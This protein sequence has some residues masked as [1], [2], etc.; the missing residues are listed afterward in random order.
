MATLADFNSQPEPALTLNDFAGAPS[1]APQSSV[2]SDTAINMAAHAAL[3]SP[4]DQVGPTY[5][6]V[7]TELQTNGTSPTL[8]NVVS[9]VDALDEAAKYQTVQ[10]ALADPT[11]SVDDKTKLL[12]AYTND[13]VVTSSTLSQKVAT[14]AA[15]APSNPAQDN[16][17]TEFT[18]INVVNTMDQVDAYNGYVSQQANAIRNVN[19][20][21]GLSNTLD[22][23]EG[24]VPFLPEASQA[25]F[26][27][28]LGDKSPSSVLKAMTLL[29]EN[30]QETADA[31]AAMPVAQRQQFAETVVNA[32]KNSGGSI[33]QRPNDLN[34]LQEVTESLQS[35]AYTGTDRFLDDLNS[36]L[37]LTIVGGPVY[38]VA[39]NFVKGISTIAGGSRSAAD[40]ARANAAVDRLSKVTDEAVTSAQAAEAA[41]TEA[42]AAQAT[43]TP[44][45]PI[46]AAGE[47]PTSQLD[48]SNQTTNP[49]SLSGDT[50]EATRKIITDN[51]HK[52]MSDMGAPPSVIADVKKQIGDMITPTTLADPKLPLQIT[53]RMRKVFQSAS[54]DPI[55][56]QTLKD[57]RDYVTARS[58]IERRT[59]RTDVDF[60]SPSQTIKDVNPGKARALFEAS[61]ADETGNVAKALYGTTPDEAAGNDILPEIAEQGGTVRGKVSQNDV[62]PEPDQDL[63]FWNNKSRGMNYFSTAEKDA[64]RNTVASDFNNVVGLTPRREMQQIDNTDTGVRISQVYGP[65]DGGFAKASDAANQVKFALRKYGV[66]DKDVEVLGRNAEG[67]FAP[68]DPKTA[69][70]GEYVARVNYNY[71]FDPTDTVNWTMTSSNKFARMFDSIPN[72]VL[73]GRS[74]GI[75]DHVFP[76]VNINDDLITRGANTVAEKSGSIYRGFEKLGRDWASKLNK[77]PDDQK[78][79]VQ[80]YILKAN[81][82]GIKFNAQAMKA[83]GFSD[84]AVDTVRAWK[85]TWDTMWHYENIDLNQSLRARGWQRYVDDSGKSDLVV[86]PV[87]KGNVG[88]A[89]DLMDGAGAVTHLTDDELNKLYEAGG[90]V[91]EIRRPLM[92][93]GKVIDKIIVKNNSEGSYLRRILDHDPTLNYRDG[94]YAVRYNQPYFITKIMKGSN[95]REFEQAVATAGSRQEA[96]ALLDR[97]HSTDAQGSY[98]LRGDVKR[99][100]PRYDDYNWDQIVSSGRSPQRIRGKRLVDGNAVVTDPN[101]INI[102]T[103]QDSLVASM[104]SIS[105]RIVSRQYIEAAKRRWLN[106][107]ADTLK[108]GDTGVFPS[109]VRDVGRHTKLLNLSHVG[110]AKVT[111]RY[112]NMM[113]NGYN[114]LI[115]DGSKALFNYMSD[116]SGRSKSWAW[117][118]KPLRTGGKYGPIGAV[119]KKAFRLFLAANP[120]RQA[121]VQAMQ[122]VPT[123]LATNPMGI[124]RTAARIPL[125]EGFRRGLTAE[126]MNIWFDKASQLITGL[127][128]DQA[129]QMYE[130]WKMSGYDA[131]VTNNSLIRDDLTRLRDQNFVQKLNSVSKIPLDVGQKIGFEFGEGLLMNSMWLSEYDKLLN[132]GVKI[133]PEVL[134]NMN[135]RVRNLTG[136]MNR[137]GELPYNSNAFSALMQFFQAPHKAFAAMLVGHKGLNPLEARAVAAASILTYGIGGNY[138]TAQVDQMLP[139]SPATSP[140]KDALKNGMFDLLMNKALSILFHQPSNTD[141][142]DSLRLV[143]FPDMFRFMTSLTRLNLGDAMS[144]IPAVSL[145]YGGS[146]RIT[147]FV[148]EFMRLF[149]V[150]STQKPQQLTDTAK[151]FLNMF[152]GMSNFFKAQYIMKYHETMSSS[153]SINDYSPDDLD[154]I[155]ALAG[156]RSYNE[157]ANQAFNE[158]EYQMSTKPKDDVNHWLTT[159][160]QHLAGEGISTEDTRYMTN[161]FREANRVWA[162]NPYYMRLVEQ[163]MLYKASQGKADTFGAVMKLIGFYGINDIQ[164]LIDNS[165]LSDDEKKTV[166]D[167]AHAIESSK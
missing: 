21:S 107:F 115:D 55:N 1:N 89:E 48:L 90:T 154:A 33:T 27:A 110:D 156:F 119:R 3:L 36:L 60:A 2:N 26:N 131:S 109:D 37:D 88:R 46:P 148:N 32:I 123:I 87:T 79:L 6:S 94:Y 40:I 102:E 11:V 59:A 35:G 145:V 113:D 39:K 121:P 166:M 104:R 141:F 128:K 7:R 29:G 34:M 99:G 101:H 8:D 22:I 5:N 152:G 38:K 66:S 76:L 144:S 129:A 150:D 124:A 19:N 15:I 95:G 17:E 143:Q 96:D 73:S 97:L 126:D 165:P 157:V 63:I 82:D 64:M 44:T 51:L 136:N 103:P 106:Q 20:T 138:L 81:N 158:N 132:D 137:A 116:V 31:I 45:Q 133:T 114:N 41:P 28:A 47:A 135:A 50:T 159:M 117:L 142:S 49:A 57:I 12:S 84:N 52:E 155:M 105:N 130:H 43:V 120:L 111:W 112:I 161:I 74:G 25:K 91:A 163:Q 10:N 16:D 42:T 13:N 160:D 56:P 18:R 9:Q 92:V 100:D 122:A 146:P 139:D 77:L 54:L 67:N 98:N 125:L 147:H 62:A 134:E 167:A 162:G 70:P 83:V 4:P 30:R 69:E 58:T 118:E 78:R 86:R 14:A 53:N 151:A 149:S 85:K 24:L 80:S 71:E 93:D 65:K 127:S 68:V 23:A 61:Q 108:G 153:G 164:N 140:I 72:I 75:I